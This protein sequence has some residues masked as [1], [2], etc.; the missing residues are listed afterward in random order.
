MKSYL[1]FRD[2]VIVNEVNVHA[3]KDKPLESVSKISS[4]SIPFCCSFRLRN[5]LN[6]DHKY[7]LDL[8]NATS[9]SFC[10][11]SLFQ[12]IYL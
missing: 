4:Q 11:C 6:V 8:V 2:A 9:F 1:C 10:A 3:A 12:Y 5:Y 7:K